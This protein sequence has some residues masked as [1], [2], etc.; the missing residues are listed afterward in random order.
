MINSEL[1]S[2]S[3]SYRRKILKYIYR[4]KAGRVAAYRALIFSMFYTMK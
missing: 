2:K 1:A 4:A 3:K